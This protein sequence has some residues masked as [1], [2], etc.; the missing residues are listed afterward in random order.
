MICAIGNPVFD[1][2]RTPRISTD[3]RV[4]SGCSTNAALAYARLGGKTAMVGSLG[5]DH[6]AGLEEYLQKYGIEYQLETCPESGGFKLDYDER[7]DRD[8][9]VLG[10]ADP[11]TDFPERFSS[12]DAVL[13]GP[14]LQ[15]IT[16]DYIFKLRERYDGVMFL[17][18]QG[19]LRR[20]DG[21]EIDHFRPDGIEKVIGVFDYVKPNELETKVLTGIDPRQDVRAA[22]KKIKSWG[23]KIVIITLAEAGSVIYDGQEFIDIPPFVTDAIDPTGAGDTYAGG[24]LFARLS[25]AD[26]E[27]AGRFASCTSSVMIEHVGP[28]FPLTRE[29][30]QRRVE[31]LPQ[32]SDVRIS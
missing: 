4:L 30:V 9:T 8:L 21:D 2:I 5:L 25:G 32:P 12:Y 17:D 18:P 11:I 28:D 15:E 27:S 6:R 3:G 10:I 26:L 1:D 31:T 7:G 13:I 14:I 23:P 29:E 24:F 16:T 22:A 20:L 19:L